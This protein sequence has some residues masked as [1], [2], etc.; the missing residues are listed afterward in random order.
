MAE[1][2]LE[3]SVDVSGTQIADLP[4]VEGKTREEAEQI[5]EESGFEV[6]VK[7]QESSPENKNLVT[8]VAP[9]GGKGAT[10]EVGSMVTITVGEGPASVEVRDISS[11]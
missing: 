3:I 8:G 4:N 10:A 5:L 1:R 6:E 9:Q 11:H 2:G 7:T